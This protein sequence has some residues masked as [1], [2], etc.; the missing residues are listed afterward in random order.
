MKRQNILIIWGMILILLAY[1]YFFQPEFFSHLFE[2]P[3]PGSPYVS[4]P[5]E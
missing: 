1:F 3:G 5:E 2:Y 4:T